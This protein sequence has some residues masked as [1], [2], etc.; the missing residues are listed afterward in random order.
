MLLRN[1]TPY[2]IKREFILVGPVASCLC[3]QAR[4]D[5]GGSKGVHAEDFSEGNVASVWNDG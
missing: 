3:A 5:R 4:S 2:T 1:E